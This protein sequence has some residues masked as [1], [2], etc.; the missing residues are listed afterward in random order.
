M[1]YSL[2]KSDSYQM[3]NREIFMDYSMILK[4]LNKASLFD[5][6]RIQAAIDQQ[7]DNPARIKE[8]KRL[9]KPGMEISYFD[10]TEN[11]LI[12][13]IIISLR[14][15]RLLVEN[16]HDGK[17]WTI[18]F[19][20]VNL[21][22]VE[23]DISTHQVI[24]RTQLKVGDSV[25]YYNR[26]NKETYGKVIKLNQ[27]TA[28]VFVSGGSKWRVPYQLLFK[29]IDIEK[30]NTLLQSNTLLKNDRQP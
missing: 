19:Y 14:Q 11:R 13:A 5:L 17:R 1:I 2:I 23:T 21:D 7:L 29:L 25:G 18:N 20:M 6:F 10:S 24:D 26:E 8:V 27:K 16:K 9:L 12:D 30:S 28:T 15:S 22:R 3:A 4:E